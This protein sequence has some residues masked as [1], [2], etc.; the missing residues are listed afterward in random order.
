MLMD[1][2]IFI[3]LNFNNISTCLGLRQ[4]QINVTDEDGLLT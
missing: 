4:V 2:H 1:I 3:L